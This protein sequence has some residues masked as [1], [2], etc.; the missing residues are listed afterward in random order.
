M[1][2]IAR[3]AS[4]RAAAA[5]LIVAA[6]CGRP[7][8]PS[9]APSASP[10][11]APTATIAQIHVVTESRGAHPTTFSAES[12][13][14]RMYYGIA[15]SSVADRLP[16]GTFVIALAQPHVIF[17]DR[18]GKTLTGDAPKALVQERTKTI[19]MSGGVRARTQEGTVLTCDTMTYDGTTER[20]HGSGDVVLV[21]PR[22]D[23]L[24][25]DR[26]DGDVRLNQVSVTSAP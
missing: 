17:Y 18:E 14:R 25:G 2:G 26:I 12:H 9:P 24:T 13:N 3:R 7:A 21:S 15:K 5:L 6:G 11:P 20:I 22:G 16:D 4:E 8:P 1:D 19:T 23:R 10:A